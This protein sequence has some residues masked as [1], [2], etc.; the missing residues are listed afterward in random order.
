M[1]LLL[2]VSLGL[3]LLSFLGAFALLMPERL[4]GAI[5]PPLVALAAG[6]LLGGALFHLLPEMIEE[7]GDAPEI[8]GYL[9]LSFLIFFILEQF[10]HWHHCHRSPLQ[11]E[12]VG[13][14]LLLAGGVH[15]FLDGLILGAAFALSPSLG[16]L[17]ALLIATHEVPQAL[18]DFGAL[19]HSGFSPKRALLLNALSATPLILGSL[20]TWQLSESLNPALL[21]PL[22]AGGFLYVAASDLIPSLHSGD[23]RKQLLNFSFLIFGM[24]ILFVLSYLG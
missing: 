5:I 12:P 4:F 2:A 13:Y 6:A 20:L 24:G 16:L 23:L 22:A 1:S 17:T 11:H 18:G 14:M 8:W 7:L 10:L 15:A 9:A 19:V 3:V 21:L